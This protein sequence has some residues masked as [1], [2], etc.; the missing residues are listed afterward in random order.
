MLVRTSGHERVDHCESS[1]KRVFGIFGPL[2]TR[3]FDQG[4]KFDNKNVK[5]LQDVFVC[6]T[7]KTT[8]HRPQGNSMS[9]RIH[10]TLHVK[11][12]MYGNI[13]Q[14]SWAEVPPFIQLAHNTSFSST[15]HET[16]FF[17]IFGRQARLPIDIIFG[18]PHVS[19]S[20]TS[21]TFA[22]LTRENLPIALELA[23]RNLSK[24]VSK[25]SAIIFKLPP[26]PEF[27]LGQEVLV[28]YKPHQS[29]DGPT[30]KLI[31]TWRR[32][33]IIFSKLSPVVYRIR[34]PDDMKQVSVHLAHKQP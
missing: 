12:S 18:V 20:P 19:R 24:R 10:S 29:T 25:R 26:I 1:F 31:Q 5:Q 21:E 23:G 7:T 15:M 17:L 2:E 16:S 30:S 34:L 22:H 11:L 27:T 6:I 14:N 9:E 4:P 3:H 8:P 28:V 32:P 13:A 33:Y